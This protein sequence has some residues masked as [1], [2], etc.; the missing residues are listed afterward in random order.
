MELLAQLPAVERDDSQLWIAFGNVSM[1]TELAG[2]ERPTDPGDIAGAGAWTSQLSGRDSEIAVPFPT[3][4]QS[5]SPEDLEAIDDELGFS[6]LDVD[7]FIELQTPPSTFLAFTGVTDADTV[8]ASLGDADDGVFSVGDGDDFEIDPEKR[9]PARPIGVPLRLGAQ[10][11]LIGVSPSTPLMRSWLGGDGE[12]LADDAAMVAVAERLDAAGPYGAYLV[13]TNGLSSSTNPYDTV[14]V[15]LA[16]EDG[17]ALGV[18]VYHYANDDDAADAVTTIEDLLGGTSSA[19]AQPW[20]EVFSSWEIEA[21]EDIVEFRL[22]FVDDKLTS[23]LWSA[24]FANDTL[25][26]P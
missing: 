17:D 20:S 14:G 13:A 22:R 10:D 25:F 9:S 8:T 4:G 2:A 15:A 24:L 3:T 7:V 18:I 23:V 19:T 12:T 6:L 5:R 16:V 11:G 26:A 21:T 1:A